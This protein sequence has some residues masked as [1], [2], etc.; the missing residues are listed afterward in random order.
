MY[1][2]TDN[3]LLGTFGNGVNNDLQD[4]PGFTPG[5]LQIHNNPRD[6][7]PA[8]NA[9]LFYTPDLGHQG[10]SARRFFYGPGVENFDMTLSEDVAVRANRSRSNSD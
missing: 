7:R 5:P 10:T 9:S 4:T 1:D 6:G 8:F 3:S 2:N